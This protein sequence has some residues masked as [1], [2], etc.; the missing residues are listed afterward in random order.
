MCNPLPL[1]YWD[2][3][4]APLHPV[5]NKLDEHTTQVGRVNP[6]TGKLEKA[7]K[8]VQHWTAVGRGTFQTARMV[9]WAEVEETGDI[10]LFSG[11]EGWGRDCEECN[12][13]CAYTKIMKIH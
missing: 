9:T 10:S 13:Y 4:L 3:S 1:E 7:L 12:R 5:S 6:Q 8:C 2:Y 11:T